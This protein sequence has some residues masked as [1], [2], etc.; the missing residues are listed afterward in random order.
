MRQKVDLRLCRQ[1]NHAGKLIK[2]PS[3]NHWVI[4]HGLTAYTA[5]NLPFAAL[6]TELTILMAENRLND[7]NLKLNEIEK[8]NLPE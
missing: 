5:V 8:E 7:I 6:S 3:F 4:Q 2:P 1:S